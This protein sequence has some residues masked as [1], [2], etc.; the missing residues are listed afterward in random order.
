MANRIEFQS[1]ARLIEMPIM[2]EATEVNRDT[3]QSFKGVWIT[4][5]AIDP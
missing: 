4:S 3:M 2:E 5:N 1:I